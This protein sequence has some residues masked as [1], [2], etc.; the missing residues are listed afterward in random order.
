[1]VLLVKLCYIIPACNSINEMVVL[2]KE[3]KAGEKEKTKN[4]KTLF[5]EVCY[6]RE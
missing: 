4:P 2:S 5:T 6:Y 3:V 1:M